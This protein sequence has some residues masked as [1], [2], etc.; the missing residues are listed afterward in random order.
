[1]QTL[2]LIPGTSRSGIVITTGLFIGF[3]RYDASR[4]S[5]LLSIPVIIGATSLESIS[6][7]SNY[8]FF[9]N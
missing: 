1:M 6:L 3:N 2:A 8:G 4:F 7:Y 5:L 9:F